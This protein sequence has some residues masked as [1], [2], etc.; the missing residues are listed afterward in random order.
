[1]VQK[2][3]WTSR[4]RNDLRNIHEYIA[5]DSIRYAQVQIENI[6]AA[7]S[8]LLSFPAMGRLVPEF[9][10]L[11]YRELIV[12]NYRIL[13]RYEEQQERVLVMTVVHGRRLITEAPQ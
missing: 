9:P 6:L 4:A 3:E 8:N 12:G 13:Y 7:V 1:M 10:H 2:I 5:A 11:P